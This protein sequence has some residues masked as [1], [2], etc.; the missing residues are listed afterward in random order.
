MIGS[1]IVG[2]GFALIL[3]RCLLLNYFATVLR[4]R[5]M[6]RAEDLEER[7]EAVQEIA[8]HDALTGALN[9]RAMLPLLADQIQLMKRK[10][11]PSVVVMVDIDHFKRVNDN[12]GHPAGDAV[13]RQIVNT[14]DAGIRPTDKLSRFGGEE[15]LLLMPATVLDEGVD[16]V[17]RLRRAVEGLEWKSIAPGLKLTISAGLTDIGDKDTVDSVLKRVDIYLYE[18][19][20][21]G[22]NI[23]VSRSVNQA[24]S[25][26]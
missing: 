5:V 22:R 7:V 9:R 13:L 1:V 4:M 15:F 24:S 2:L 16:V 23:N 26:N 21:S 11:T 10:N 14:I 20:S 19:K 17:E 18:A 3:L 12:Y 8:T 6:S 25:G